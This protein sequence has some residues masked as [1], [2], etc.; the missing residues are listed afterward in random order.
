M[1]T[2]SEFIT[3]LFQIEAQAHVAH[4]QTSS[5]AQH[6]ALDELYKG[7]VE[8]RDTYAETYQGRYG[9]IKGYGTIEIK[10]GIDMV[11]YLNQTVSDVLEYRKQITD[12]YLQQEIDNLLE[13][14]NGVLYKLRFLK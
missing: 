13:L 10:E 3:K 7:M 11:Q 5:F 12:G 1:K 2:T 6:M 4:L 8:L 9:I 14:I